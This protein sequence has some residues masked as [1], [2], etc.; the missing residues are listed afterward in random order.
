MQILSKVKVRKRF[1]RA[2]LPVLLREHSNRSLQFKQLASFYPLRK[3]RSLGNLRYYHQLEGDDGS[4][5]ATD[6][7]ESYAATPL[8]L[9]SH[10]RSLIIPRWRFQ[11]H[12]RQ[13][14]PTPASLMSAA[15]D[16]SR[17]GVV[18]SLL[19]LFLIYGFCYAAILR[20]GSS[21]R[22]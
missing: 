3:A 19:R 1:G 13:L 18:C 17:L 5:D 21:D 6:C 16:A 10:Q 15:H 22:S 14:M 2:L 8:Y 11:R 4:I 9:N 12:A 20:A 7:S